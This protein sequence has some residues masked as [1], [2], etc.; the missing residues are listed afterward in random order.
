MSGTYTEVWVTGDQVQIG[1]ELLK[2]K[3]DDKMSSPDQ[4]M[5]NKKS[6]VKSFQAPGNGDRY[7]GTD[8]SFSVGPTKRLWLV[9][10]ATNVLGVVTAVHTPKAKADSPWNG[11][12]AKCGRGTYTGLFAT[13]HEG[14]G[15]R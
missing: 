4:D 14:G 11:K 5:F 10:R 15:C 9:R 6:V 3:M 13:E 12:C 2:Y 1:D 7:F 8:G